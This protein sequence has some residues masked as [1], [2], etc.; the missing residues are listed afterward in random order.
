MLKK[1]AILGGGV[2]GLSAAHELIERGYEVS[3]YEFK[4]IPGGKARSMP[5]VGSGTGGRKDLPGE[6]GFRLF[7]RFYRHVIDT[8]KRIPYENGTVYD[9]LTEVTRLDIATYTAPLLPLLAKIEFSLD[10]LLVL[11]KDLFD[12]NLGLSIDDMEQYGRKLWQ[13]M[14]SC[15]ERIREEYNLIDWWEFIE[16]EQQSPAFQK[17]FA[18]FTKTLVACQSKIA[19]TQTVGPVAVQMTLDITTPGTS[20]VRLLNGPTNDKWIYP[21]LTFLQDQGLHYHLGANVERINCQDGQVRSATITLNGE[22]FD[23]DADYFIAAFPVE[24]MGKMIT[25]EML[26]IDPSLQGVQKL[27]DSVAWMNG[28]Q[29]YLREELPITHGHVIYL[30]APWSLTSVSQKQF[31]P[32]VN[33]S[34]YGDGTVKGI[35]SVDISDWDTP[36]ILFGKTAKL[37]TAEE[38]KA[39]VWAQMKL[40]LNIDGAVILEDSVLHSWFLDTDIQFVNPEHACTNMEPLL[41]NRVGTWEDR[42]EALTG[43]PNLFLASDYVRTNTNLATMEGAN[44]AARR[45]VNAILLCDESEEEPCKIWEMYTFELGHIDVL[46]MYHIHDKK[47]LDKGLPWDGK[48]L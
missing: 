3:V 21:W 13:I 16:A 9:N 11:I 5:Y 30:D 7:P 15:D 37:C 43:I 23:I 39:E 32:D 36:G 17:I 48:M 22:T 24:V 29:Y 46:K 26:E 14:T 38:I 31:W 28:I 8:L 45:A 2:A 41:I 44:E 19:N 47:R 12:N 42:P 20:F 33:L 10:N 18:G 6:H 1:V 34:E 25:D 4:Q 35:L 27:V 40:S